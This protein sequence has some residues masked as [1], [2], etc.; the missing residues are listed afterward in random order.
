MEA[1]R[2]REACSKFE[3][4]DRLDPGGGTVLN[5]A[6]CYE[7]TGRYVAA[8]AALIDGL[9]RAIRQHRKDREDLAREHLASVERR[10]ATIVIVGRVVT[11]ARVDGVRVD[12][13]PGGRIFVDPGAHVV[14][15]IPARPQTI[16]LAEGEVRMLDIEGGATPNAKP[17]KEPSYGGPSTAYTVSYNP[18]PIVALAVAVVGSAVMS[19]GLVRVMRDSD[20]EAGRWMAIGGGVGMIGGAL[21]AMVVPFTNAKPR[22][23]VALSGAGATV[24]F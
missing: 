18:F 7:E 24:T 19:F 13:E 15:V 16:S 3:E 22:T 9:E 12:A 11:H 1:G 10:V 6:V 20:D 23:G 21:G 5:L 8:R 2:A 14:E 17:L 4:S